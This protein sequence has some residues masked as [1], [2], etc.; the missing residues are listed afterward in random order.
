MMGRTA[1]WHV[2]LEAPAGPGYRRLHRER[3]QRRSQM[4]TKN[5]V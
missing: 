1:V 5:A 4:Q 3:G 2:C